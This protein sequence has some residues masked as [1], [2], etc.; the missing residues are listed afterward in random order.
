MSKK[1]KVSRKIIAIIA[2]LFIVNMGILM[3]SVYVTQNWPSSKN[4]ALEMPFSGP[5]KP[6]SDQ[7][8]VSSLSLDGFVQAQI[9]FTGNLLVVKNGCKGIPMTPTEQQIRS[10]SS[11]L[12]NQTDFRPSTHD[13]MKDIF[14]TYGIEVIQS[15]IISAEEN[16]EVYYAR[17]VVKKDDKIL[18]LDTNPSDT[19]A[20]ALRAGVPIYINK[21]LLEKRGANLCGK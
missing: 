6:L 21:E 14:D 1:D 11:A 19:M 12:N 4:K 20:M 16:D 2:V 5:I 9:E 3:A 8:N 15:K 7:S 17:L 13:L 18:N 10:I